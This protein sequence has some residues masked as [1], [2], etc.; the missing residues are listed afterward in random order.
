MKIVDTRGELCPA[1][2]I[3][4]KRALKEVAEGEMFELLT[5]NQ[6]SLDN[7]SRFLKDNNIGFTVSENAGF[8]LMIIT[9]GRNYKNLPDAGNYCKDIKQNVPHFSKGDFV[10]AFSSDTMGDGDKELGH[11]LM[12]NFIKSLKDLDTLPDKMVFY[13]RGVMLGRNGSPGV[14]HLK[15]LEKMG[16]DILICSTC[17]NHFS[18][19]QEISVGRISNIFEI[20][21]IMASAGNVIKP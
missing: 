17:I 1:P 9:A 20:T 2:I 18:I 12:E 16:V 19:S 7:V 4:A 14:G 21:Q 11:L 5:D 8:W 3:A 13:N 10:V 6:T 15:D